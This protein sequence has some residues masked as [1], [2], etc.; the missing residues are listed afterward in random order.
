MILNYVDR[1]AIIGKENP[2][3]IL[4]DIYVKQFTGKETAPY[5]DDVSSV[6]I[7]LLNEEEKQNVYQL[8]KL[9]LLIIIFTQA[10]K[11]FLD[12]PFNNR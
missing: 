7:T 6:R 11:N 3:A 8:L 12:L 9:L 5:G 10:S 4:F 2:L 1:S